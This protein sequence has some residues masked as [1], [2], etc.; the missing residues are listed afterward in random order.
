MQLTMIISA[1]LLAAQPASTQ[2]DPVKG[3]EEK[4]KLPEVSHSAFKPGERLEFDV[5]Y[6]WIDAGEAIIEIKKDQ[7]EIAG[8]DVWHVV[9]KGNST[10]TFNWFFKVRDTYET[11][12]DAEGVFPWI[13]VR[14]VHEGG[15]EIKQYYT[16]D[17]Y[18]GE[19]K[20][21]KGKAYEIPLG[22]QDM[23]SSFY[24]ARAID[25]SNAKP[26][27][28]FEIQAF[29]DDKVWPLKIRYLKDEIVKTDM[30]KFNCK[31]FVPVVQEG[32]IFK[33]EED[34]MVWVTNDQNK[35]PVM[36]KA[37]VLVGSITMELRDYSGLAHPIARID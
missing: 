6:G 26:N 22:V 15:Y 35:I 7:T 36:A 23:I 17:H 19:V 16:F 24:R 14:D 13:F 28:V 31:V 33:E 20:N 18:K 5:S 1:F 9:G 11:Y 12:L 8:R 32:R 3:K 25:Y 30:G 37:K 2:G 10:G 34:M 29:V 27:E 21:D 4:V